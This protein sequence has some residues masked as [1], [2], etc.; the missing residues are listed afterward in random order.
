MTLNQIGLLLD[1]VGVLIL[2]KYG[3]PSEVAENSDGYF[4]IVNKRPQEELDEEKRKNAFIKKMA[5]LGLASVLLG[6][7][8]QFIATF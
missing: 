1:I 4:L 2:F 3:L 8:F 7:T 6:F 5:Y